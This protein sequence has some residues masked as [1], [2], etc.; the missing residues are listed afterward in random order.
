[1]P[2]NT[3][4][5]TDDGPKVI[6][7]SI[8][9]FDVL[10]DEDS[11][12]D[13]HTDPIDSSDS[14]ISDSSQESESEN[15]RSRAGDSDSGRSGGGRSNS[16][17]SS[18]RRSID[19][20]GFTTVQSRRNN[21]NIY[22]HNNRTPNLNRERQISQAEHDA[23]WVQMTRKGRRAKFQEPMVDL[24]VSDEVEDYEIVDDSE[25]FQAWRKLHL[26]VCNVFHFDFMRATMP[27]DE[28][29]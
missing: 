2:R 4:T 20:D 28:N 24:T 29:K 27:F 12:S 17:R 11:M 13:M 21:R 1:M 9:T 3:K 15:E 16:I 14:N 25:G 19:S 5:G 22:T 26:S 6:Q 7:P 8:N 23:G 10:M 18:D